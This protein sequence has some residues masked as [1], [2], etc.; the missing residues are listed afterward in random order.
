MSDLGTVQPDR[1]GVIGRSS[2]MRLKNGSRDLHVDY[3]LEGSVRRSA[4]RVR[5]TARLIKAAD[6][7]EAWTGSYEQ[8]ESELF[9]MQEDAAAQISAGRA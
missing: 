9:Q 2:V 8:N 3:L 1:L 6:Q 4:G 7:S 5:V